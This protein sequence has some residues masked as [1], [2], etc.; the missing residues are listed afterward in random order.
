VLVLQYDCNITAN[1]ARYNPCKSSSK[2]N[3]RG[4]TGD[5]ERRGTN[6]SK[7]R[8]KTKKKTGPSRVDN[9]IIEKNL[10]IGQ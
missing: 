8:T 5:E 7:S 10:T 2:R 1:F 6:Q 4:M 3:V 9:Y